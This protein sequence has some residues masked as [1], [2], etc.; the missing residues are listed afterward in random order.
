MP[1]IVAPDEIFDAATNRTKIVNG[2]SSR[3][4]SQYPRRDFNDLNVRLIGKIQ[5]ASIDTDRATA[6]NLSNEKFE[7]SQEC[8]N[9]RGQHLA[10]QSGPI[11]SKI[12]V[13]D[14]RCRSW[15]PLHS[16]RSRETR[17]HSRG[18]RASIQTRRGRTPSANN[19]S[20]LIL[21]IS[22][23]RRRHPNPLQ[24]LPHSNRVGS[25]ALSRR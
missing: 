18:A 15:W 21:T 20:P 7:L 17:P 12:T 24:F 25:R 3:P 13:L 5:H 8:K 19:P 11:D 6:P 9:S 23:G 4:R 14:C 16:R 1:S 2:T 22:T 10:A